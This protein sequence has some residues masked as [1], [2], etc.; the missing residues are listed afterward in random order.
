VQLTVRNVDENLSDALKREAKK[1]GQSV[2]KLI[3]DILQQSLGIKSTSEKPMAYTDLD[4][5]AATWQDEETD[6]FNACVQKQRKIDEE[7]WS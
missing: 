4:H 2:N 3:I 5:L 1:R 6:Q 7:M